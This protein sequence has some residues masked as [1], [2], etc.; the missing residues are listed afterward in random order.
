ME[1]SESRRGISEGIVEVVRAI[2]ERRYGYA[3]RLLY[4][5]EIVGTGH[6]QPLEK[7]CEPRETERVVQLASVGAV[8][9]HG[10]V[11]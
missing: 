2:V 7:L 11:R 6:R 8:P 1:T 9:E 5:L 4:A 3:H 10:G